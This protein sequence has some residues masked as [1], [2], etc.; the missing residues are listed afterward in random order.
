MEKSLFVT[1]LIDDDDDDR[2]IFQLALKKTN[3]NVQHHSVAD[4]YQALELLSSLNFNPD[5][6]FLDL[7]MPKMSGYDCLP[8]IKKLVHLKNVPVIIYT[9]SSSYIDKAKLLALGAAVF[10]TKPFSIKK[11]SGIISNVLTGRFS[12]LPED[13][14]D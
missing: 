2:E 8:E 5:F 14:E 1:L 7:N 10:V 11:L 3:F 12:D 4:G 6:I 9:T 13:D